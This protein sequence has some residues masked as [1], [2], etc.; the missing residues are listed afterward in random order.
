MT[1][2]TNMADLLPFSPAEIGCGVAVSNYNLS[3]ALHRKPIEAR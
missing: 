2:S 1:L 3:R